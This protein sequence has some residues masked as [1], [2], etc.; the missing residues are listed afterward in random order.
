MFDMLSVTVSA[1]YRLDCLSVYVCLCLYV[2]ACDARGVC[3]SVC[4]VCVCVCACD[5]RGRE[6]RLNCHTGQ[7]TRRTNRCDAS[8]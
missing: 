1:V 3:Q 5:T 6:L 7:V 4:G 2:C 8:A